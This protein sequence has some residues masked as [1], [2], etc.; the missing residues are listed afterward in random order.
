MAW[1]MSIT[2]N[3]SPMSAS[4][5]SFWWVKSVVIFDNLTSS[6]SL[7]LSATAGSLSFS[8][9]EHI[10]S[11]MKCARLALFSGSARTCVHCFGRGTHRPS[12]SSN[13]SSR[14]GVSYS[15]NTLDGLFFIF[16]EHNLY[17]LITVFTMRQPDPQW[18]LHLFSCQVFSE[19]PPVLLQW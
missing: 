10:S 3:T 13:Q 19:Q 9:W 16:V 15:G 8:V 1:C 5:M 12:T 18:S 2:C 11:N 17:L 7:K 4:R 14:F 6:S